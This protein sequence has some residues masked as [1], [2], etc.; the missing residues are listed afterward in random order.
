[1]LNPMC[2]YNKKISDCIVFKTVGLLYCLSVVAVMLMLIVSVVMFDC[3]LN[4]CVQCNGVFYY[5]QRGSDELLTQSAVSVMAPATPHHA[6]N[7][8]QDSA[9]KVSNI[10][11]KY[12]YFSICSSFKF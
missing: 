2:V 11:R 4:V 10:T 12:F 8:N 5:L 1:M 9:K 3:K 6:D 7:N